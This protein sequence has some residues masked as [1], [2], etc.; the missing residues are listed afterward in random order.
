MTYED[1][2]TQ[3]ARRPPPF[4][5]ADVSGPGAEAAAGDITP[6]ADSLQL[7]PGA[8]QG[9]VTIPSTGANDD[10]HDEA[11]VGPTECGVPARCARRSGYVSSSSARSA[12]SA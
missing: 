12:H 10:G 11:V 8:A 2:S 4:D 1:G 9:T 3:P 5:P 7:T 6:R